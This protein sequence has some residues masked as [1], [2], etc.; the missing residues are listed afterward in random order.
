MAGLLSTVVQLQE[1]VPTGF[2][3]TEQ[4]LFDCRVVGLRHRR[5]HQEGQNPCCLCQCRLHRSIG[6]L[7]GQW[8][9]AQTPRRCQWNNVLASRTF[10]GR[11][12]RLPT[13]NER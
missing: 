2:S 7:E 13:P 10:A 1:N 9:D 3:I 8:P 11:P 4:L 12:D 6:S 5:G